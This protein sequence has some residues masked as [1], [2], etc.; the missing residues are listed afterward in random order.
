MKHLSFVTLV[1]FLL[2]MFLLTMYSCES[3]EIIE[4]VDA[5]GIFI[6]N[7]SKNELNVLSNGSLLV[8][9]KITPK[10][11]TS[12]KDYHTVLFNSSDT[13][14]FVVDANGVITGKR[15]GTARLI[16]T[17]SSDDCEVKGSCVVR[18][19]GQV[20]V[21]AIN[22]DEV[23][24]NIS[25][26]IFENPEFQ[27]HKEHFSVLP[28]N[29]LIRDVIFAS[30]D[31]TIASVDQNGLI[32]GISGGTAIIS[33]LSTDGSNAKAEITVR[34]LA[35]INTWYLEERRNFVFDYMPGLI[36][37]PLNSDGTGYGDKWEY[38]I[39]EGNNWEA[40]FIS[41]SK[42][43]KASAP[44]AAIGD[45]FIPI[46]MQ[47]KLKFNKIFFRHRSTNTLARLRIW[48]FDLLG[49]DDGVNF[50]TLQDRIEI[51]GAKVDGTSNIEATIILDKVYT[52]RYIKIVPTEWDNSSG[53]TMQVSDLKIGYD[54]SLDPE[55]F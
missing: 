48:K 15:N 54:E 34:I 2:T 55:F 29:A 25:I 3:S 4:G 39:D 41:L 17:A 36:K 19:T 10:E 13:N 51:P 50:Y 24:K 37:Y 12:V 23:V 9:Y 38:L 22:L 26:N 14:I 28:E 53:N 20:F 21:E 45:V 1:C 27:I 44:G 43:G 32:T 7:S 35:P 46:D 16:I 31:P 40:S 47:Q 49:S 11:N 30:S 42:P 6:T 5:G 8:E 18:V 33:I 52:S